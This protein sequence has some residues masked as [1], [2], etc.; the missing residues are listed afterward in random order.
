MVEERRGT[1]GSFEDEEM[2]EEGKEVEGKLTEEVGHGG[3]AGHFFFSFL[4]ISKIRNNE[5]GELLR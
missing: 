4:L 2:G 3:I 5:E 1:L